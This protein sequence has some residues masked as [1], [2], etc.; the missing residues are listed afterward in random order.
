MKQNLITIAFLF[1]I[2]CFACEKHEKIETAELQILNSAQPISNSNSKGKSYYGISAQVG[3]SGSTCPGCVNTG[4]N[5]VHVD[6]Q[7]T[8]TACSVSAVMEISDSGEINFYYGTIDEPNELTYEE[9]FL[10]PNRSLYIIGSNGK[11][12]NIP[13]QI[14]YRDEKT[15][16]F[17]FYDIFFSDAQVFI[18]E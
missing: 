18:N 4:G 1:L 16:A 14:A 3:H 11:F 12:L 13:E 10:M 5:C 2:L 17:V 9:T 15:G 7:G 6:C 8:G